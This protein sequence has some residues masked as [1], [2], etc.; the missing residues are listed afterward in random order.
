MRNLLLLI[1]LLCAGTSQAQYE[2]SSYPAFDHFLFQ[3]D[4]SH[5]G[6]RAYLVDSITMDSIDLGFRYVR[7]P[8]QLKHGFIYVRTSD[9]KGLVAKS[10]KMLLGPSH[11]LRFNSTDSIISAYLCSEAGW[12]F[13]NFDGDTL[14]YGPRAMRNNHIPEL[15][16]TF[17]KASTTSKDKKLQWGYLGKDAR[18]VIPPQFEQVEDFENGF[19]KVMQDGKWGLIDE[20]GQFVLDPVFETSNF[21]VR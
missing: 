18:W 15:N 11:Q 8:L 3:H 12:I 21:P 4:P 20:T 9:M 16:E 7:P 10:G 2:R 13:L 1:T 17:N 5:Y 14:S 6:R 19:A